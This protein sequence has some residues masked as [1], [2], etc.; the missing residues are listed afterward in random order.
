MV[1]KVAFFLTENQNRKKRL[2]FFKDWARNSLA[3]Y[4]G[5]YFSEMQQNHKLFL[6]ENKKKKLPVSCNKDCS[7]L[8]WENVKQN[9]T[10]KNYLYF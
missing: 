10:L 9:F 7:Y 8:K 2:Y 4:C 6:E 1:F 3:F 5:L